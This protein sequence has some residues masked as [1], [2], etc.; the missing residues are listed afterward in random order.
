M[1]CP[2][3]KDIEK[4]LADLELRTL[5]HQVGSH[6]VDYRV[7]GKGKEVLSYVPV[8]IG[9][10]GFD[11]M[12]TE[13]RGNSIRTVQLDE[14]IRAHSEA[15]AT[16][17]DRIYEKSI[18]TLFKGNA[19]K[20]KQFSEDLHDLREQRDGNMI[21]KVIAGADDKQTKMRIRFVSATH[22]KVD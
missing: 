16:I 20:I 17:L 5:R 4:V 21:I 7:P 15:L 19:T 2:T 3:P 9:L 8:R 1:Q 6:S 18:S 12:V 22:S 14:A 11:C 10:N 13:G